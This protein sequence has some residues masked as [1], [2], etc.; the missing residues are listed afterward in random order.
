LLRISSD[1]APRKLKAVPW[2]R[3]QRLNYAL[4][5]LVIAHAIF[6]GALLRATSP[7][8]LLLASASPGF[9]WDRRWGSGRHGPR[10]HKAPLY[11]R[12][13]EV[14]VSVTVA[15]VTT[16]VHRMGGQRDVQMTRLLLKAATGADEIQLG[17]TDARAHEQDEH[18]RAPDDAV[19]RRVPAG[20]EVGHG[21]LR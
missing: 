11:D 12:T 15:D 6:Y 7:S 14:T 18:G 17:P 13:S 20:D 3:L 9:S 4:F 10:P 8:T 16:R 19:E 2:K 1:F 5:A 21:A